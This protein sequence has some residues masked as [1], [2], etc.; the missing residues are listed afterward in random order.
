MNNNKSNK[1]HEQE[2]FNK[3]KKNKEEEQALKQGTRTKRRTYEEQK[4]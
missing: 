4:Q 2:H 3:N 1:Q